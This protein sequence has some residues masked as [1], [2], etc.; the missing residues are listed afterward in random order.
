MEAMQVAYREIGWGA[1]A[2]IQE[3]RR[4]ALHRRLFRIAGNFAG[5]RSDICRDLVLGAVGVYLE[6]AEMT[7]L[8]AE[9]HVQVQPE[10]SIFCRLLPQ[11]PVNRT[12]LPCRPRG[13]RRVC[14]DEVISNGGRAG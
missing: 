11:N 5:Q 9:R 3:R 7:S 6:I 14:C 8:A 2:E 1:T 10:V 12:D 4:A 13:E